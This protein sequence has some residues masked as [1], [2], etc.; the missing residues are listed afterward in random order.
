[1]KFCYSH[2][3]GR[4]RR[5]TLI[6]MFGENAINAKCDS[7]C[8]DVCEFGVIQMEDSLH[9]LSILITAIDELGNRGEVKITEWIRG[10]QLTW[11]KDVRQKEET[12]YGKSPKGLSKGWW[13]NFIRQAAA[14]GFIKRIANL[15]KIVVCMYLSQLMTNEGKQ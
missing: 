10:G 6:E 4:C 2:L 12:A 15:D 8:C 14:A 7:K 9:E 11:V 1:M 13:R 3:S 5:K